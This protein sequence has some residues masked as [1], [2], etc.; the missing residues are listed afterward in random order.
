MRTRGGLTALVWKDR[1]KVYMLTIMDP[2][3]TE[4]N[5][6][7]N[8]SRP[9][10][11]HI[12]EWYKRHM[13]YVDNSDHMANSYSMSRRTFKWTTKL[14][15][16]FLDLTVLNSWIQLP[17][18]GAKYTHRDFRLLLVRNLIEE[19]GK[20]QDSPT[21]RLV[22][23]PSAAATNVLWLESR[24][25]K[26]WQGKSLTQL[27]CRVCSTCGQRKGTRYKCARCDVGLCVVPCFEEYH[28]KVNL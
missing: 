6:C 2:L 4:G 14:F 24:H 23:R 18:C 15:F 1:R 7:D 10:K 16:H 17:S 8:S 13:A 9:M 22:G 25:N 3:P 5:V 11:P 19:A 12:V 26:H 28:T 21:P 27:H 20:S